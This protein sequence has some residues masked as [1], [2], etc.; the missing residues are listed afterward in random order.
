MLRVFRIRMLLVA[1]ALLPLAGLQ[2]KVDSIE[3]RG[4]AK[5]FC[6]TIK[7]QHE[8]HSVPSVPATV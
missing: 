4:C 3:R 8:G 7:A 5:A 6:E 1:V 2:M